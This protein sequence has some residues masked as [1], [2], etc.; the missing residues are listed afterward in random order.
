MP[1]SHELEKTVGSESEKV[2]S[3]SVRIESKIGGL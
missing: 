2:K 1:I 3:N